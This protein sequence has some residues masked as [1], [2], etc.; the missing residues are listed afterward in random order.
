VRVFVECFGI[1][2]FDFVD[3]WVEFDIVRFVD[4][5]FVCCY[6]VIFVGVDDEGLLLL[7]MG[8]FIN[9][10]VIDDVMMVMGM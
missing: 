6:D 1:E 4:F 5:M 2:W 10:L 9:L 7:V 3:F 8:D